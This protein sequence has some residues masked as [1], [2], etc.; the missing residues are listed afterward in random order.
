M[1]KIFLIKNIIILILLFTNVYL[2]AQN[3][4]NGDDEINDLERVVEYERPSIPPSPTASTFT[5]FSDFVSVN[6]FTG[7]PQ[8]QIPIWTV[9]SR[10][11]SDNISISYSSNG[12]KVNDYPGCLGS[13]W[14]LNAGGVIN[15][16]VN[17][18]PDDTDAGAIYNG[19][20]NYNYLSNQDMTSIVAGNKDAEPDVFSYSFG[21]YSGSFMFDGKK[22]YV[23]TGAN[24]KIDFSTDGPNT[25]LL[26]S[27]MIT[28]DSGTRYYFEEY[29]VTETYQAM[30]HKSLIYR[31]AWYLTKIETTDNN[32]IF[33]VYG[34]YDYEQN[35]PYSYTRSYLDSV[36]NSTGH[37]WHAEGLKPTSTEREN[38]TKQLKKIIGANSNVEFVYLDDDYF[39]SKIIIRPFNSET[40]IYK[41]FNIEMVPTSYVFQIISS[42]QEEVNGETKPAYK[43]YYYDSED[44]FPQYASNAQDMWGF[45]NGHDYNQNLLPHVSNGYHDFNVGV[46]NRETNEDKMKKGILSKIVYPTGGSIELE[47]ETHQFLDEGGWIMNY[48]DITYN[49]SIIYGGGLRVKSIFNKNEYGK[50][51]SKKEFLY[52]DGHQF[53]FPTF[54]TYSRTL[55]KEYW[56]YL[57]TLNFHWRECPIFIIYSNPVVPIGSSNGSHVGYLKVTQLNTSIEENNE[58]TLGKTINYFNYDQDLED[59]YNSGENSY[60]INRNYMR[61]FNYLTEIYKNGQIISKTEKEQSYSPITYGDFYGVSVI[62]PIAPYYV[63]QP[64]IENYSEFSRLGFDYY[65]KWKYI[66]W[67]KTIETNYTGSITETINYD[68][69]N[70]EI[71]DDNDGDNDRL[72]RY[73]RSET[74]ENSNNE[75]FDIIY[76]YCFDYNSGNPTMTTLKNNNIYSSV[77]EKLVFK[78]NDLINGAFYKYAETDKCGIKL[79]EVW[80]TKIIEPVSNYS[81]NDYSPNQT[82]F[83]KKYHVNLYDDYGN[84]LEYQEENNNVISLVWGYGNLFPIAKIENEY[85]DNITLPEDINT[86]IVESNLLSTFETLRTNLENALITSFTYDELKGIHITTDINNQNTYYIYDAFGR[87]VTVKDNDEKIIKH[88][89]YNYYIDFSSD[90]WRINISDENVGYGCDVTLSVDGIGSNTDDWT[91]YS[92]SSCYEPEEIIQEGGKDLYLENVTQ[93]Q[94][95]FALHEPSGTYN[96]KIINVDSDILY[97]QEDIKLCYNE[98]YSKTI[99]V[100]DNDLCITEPEWEYEIEYIE[101]EDDWISITPDENNYNLSIGEMTSYTRISEITISI[102]E[103]ELQEEHVYRVTQYADYSFIFSPIQFVEFNNQYVCYGELVHENNCEKDYYEGEYPIPF[104][105]TS[106]SVYY[107]DTEG[108]II[109]FDGEAKPNGLSGISEGEYWGFYMD[110][111]EFFN[112]KYYI[113]CTVVGDDSGIEFTKTTTYEP[114][115]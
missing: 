62:R 111:E 109:S 80:E 6:L 12:Y 65:P 14:T 98:D 64:G 2:K 71:D 81:N 113:E 85:Y 100:F 45:Y 82:Y 63:D 97:N 35:S 72:I 4:K 43:F 93:N 38:Q 32:S 20:P 40:E 95:I 90:A 73:L 46:A 56:G 66:K 58:E 105:I 74:R 10:T 42:I 79:S 21:N 59:D 19:I 30:S 77:L 33:Y 84:I 11:I 115:N 41:Q 57:T 94:C 75:E 34:D 49:D 37:G 55:K 3:T 69:V 9:N 114:T 53:S 89:D 31:S 86:D 18:L 25:G 96:K 87:L 26:K 50:L 1:E 16:T 29:E 61:G 39:L 17:S 76:K 104:T 112:K 92:S 52:E 78:N 103:G 36:K 88:I 7:T 107:Y 47:Y 101:G 108:A 23:L 27:F 67:T 15:R 5:N 91:W 83:E 22:A 54:F 106:V 28:D 60:F 48:P 102:N 51:T 70:H 44:G 99:P 24:I 8:I 68:Y 13:G 110:E